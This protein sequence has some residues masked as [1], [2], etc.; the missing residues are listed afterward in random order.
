MKKIILSFLV[1]FIIGINILSVTAN[2]KE[3]QQFPVKDRQI[4][5]A[6]SQLALKE[7]YKNV[8]SPPQLNIL[9]EMHTNTPYIASFVLKGE[10]G[11]NKQYVGVAFPDKA[12]QKIWHYVILE[13]Q[14]NMVIGINSRGSVLTDDIYNNMLE[15]TKMSLEGG[16]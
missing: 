8:Y 10:Y 9:Q 5:A 16:I 3:I 7:F 1:A 13:M 15:S 11:Q 6:Y 2:P 14:D 12:Q 4:V